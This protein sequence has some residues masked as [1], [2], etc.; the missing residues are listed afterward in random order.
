MT[1]FKILLAKSSKHPDSPEHAESL[2]DHTSAVLRFASLL[3]T[4]LADPLQSLLELN[5]SDTDLWKQAVQVAAWQ[6]DWGKANDHFQAMIRDGKCKQGIRHESLSLVMARELE[7]WLCPI[8]ADQPTWFKRAALF[9]SSGHHLK[10]PDP[11]AGVRPGLKLRVF[12]DHPDLKAVMDLGVK[13]F[14]IDSYP[15][16]GT[17]EYSLLRRAE[18]DMAIKQLRQELDFDPTD[19]EKALIAA[20]KATMMA[21]DLAGS[22]LPQKLVDPEQW[23]VERIEKTLSQDQ[24]KQVVTTKIQGRDLRSFQ[25]ELRDSDSK[26]VLAEAGCGSGKTAGAYLWASRHAQNKRL[27]FCY[28]TTTTASEG[29]AGYLRDP[30]FDA[31]LMHSRAT[32]DYRLL[33]NMPLPNHE[34]NELRQAGLEALEAWP[35]PAVVCTTHTVLGIL[36]NVRRSL[37]TWPSLVQSV[38]VFD[39]IHAFSDR[40][41]SYLLRFLRVFTGAEVL[42]MT[43]TL[44][45]S[46]R[47]ALEDACK[48]RGGLLTVLGPQEREMA[49]RYH[50][51]DAAGNDP[52]TEVVEV[53]NNNGKVLWV[54]NT[55]RRAMEMVGDAIKRGLPVQPFHSRY[56]YRDRLKRQQAIIQG[57]KSEAPILAV[58]TQVAEMS[59]DISADLL[60]SEYAPVPAM[61]QRLGRLNRFE[62]IPLQVKKAIFIQP[63]TALPYSDE[64]YLGLREWISAVTDGTPKSQLELSQ[65]FINISETQQISEQRYNQSAF[66][67]G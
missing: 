37:Y 56:R 45:P 47:K 6:H 61:I 59:L 54:C 48:H 35:M 62:E 30:D 58:T 12:Y 64:D 15:I 41:F 55:V 44:Q 31:I 51:V 25:R 38:F 13:L 26:T 29:F 49:K 14:G 2:L 33:A 36:E 28:P 17:R 40:L 3:T 10:F 9:A 60:I 27:F 19:K 63:P 7:S 42:L 50:L 18:I 24:L 20:A 53:L 4:K 43:A 23:F 34:E 1:S 22:A 11:L 65:T 66:V 8:W 52:W 32:I 57:F 46:R 39:E 21:A 16:P 67:R 5:Q